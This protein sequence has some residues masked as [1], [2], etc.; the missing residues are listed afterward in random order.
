MKK[1]KLFYILVIVISVFFANCEK[2]SDDDNK[3]E[4]QEEEQGADNRQ[5]VIDDYNNV[6]LKSAVSS[7]GWDGDVSNCKEG[8]VSDDT[9]EKVLQRINYFR[10]MVGLPADI[11]FDDSWNT[12]CQKGALMMSANR[13]LS[14]YPPKSWK[15]YTD[16]G[17]KAAGKSNIALGTN[18]TRS[19]TAFMNDYGNGNEA[20][21]HRR[22]IIY[23]RA[24]TMG[25]GSTSNSCVLWVIGGSGSAPTDMP[26]FISWPPKGYVPSPL[27]F[28]RW[29]LSVPSADFSNATVSMTDENGGK[30]E[31]SIISTKK[32][33]GDN[34]I[35]WVPSGIKKSEAVDIKYNITVA[36]VKLSGETKQYDYSVTIVNDFN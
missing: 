26:D 3:K 1:Q 28:G 33:Y 27:I 16:D 5:Q 2:D 36:G 20:C 8:S 32:G 34:A 4:N 17:A 22:W 11:T 24:K 31:V 29:S 12:K 25:H 19:I 15:C 13:S 18:S 10:K 21:G 14:H 7:T 30:I 9:H 6:Y 23:S 35:M